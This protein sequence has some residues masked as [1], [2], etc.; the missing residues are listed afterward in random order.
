MSPHSHQTF[1]LRSH[2]LAGEP[3]PTS[4]SGISTWAWLTPSEIEERLKGQ[5]DE[6]VWERVQ[7][8]FGMMPEEQ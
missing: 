4:E 5:G 2:I 8:M 6:Q 1:F 7:L 3:N